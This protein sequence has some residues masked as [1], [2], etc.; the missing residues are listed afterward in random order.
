MP[1]CV[2]LHAYMCIP[3][4]LHA[5]S[6][7]PTCSCMMPALWGDVIFVVSLVTLIFTFVLFLVLQ[8]VVLKAYGQPVT[9]V[10]L[11]VCR[12]AKVAFP[13]ACL[14][15]TCE[16]H[17]LLLLFS[18]SVVSDS[19]QPRGLQHAGLFCL[20]TDRV[21]AY[22][23]VQSLSKAIT[24]VVEYLILDLHL[25]FLT[26]FSCSRLP[27]QDMWD[28]FV[29]SLCKLP[30]CAKILPLYP[31]NFTR[32]CLVNYPDRHMMGCLVW[33]FRKLFLNCLFK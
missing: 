4:C 11:G 15:R 20:V 10:F 18:C 1:T 24:R 28:H 19:S 30:G 2:F 6:Y 32:M 21:L 12:L 3:T 13:A 22:L 25:L 29:F 14:R 8:L 23:H 33:R 27:G 7:M 26:V 5:Y 17:T 9:F 16:Y 31:N